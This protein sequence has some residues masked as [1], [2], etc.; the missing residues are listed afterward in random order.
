VL[1]GQD[2]TG[3]L[4]I[5]T[6]NDWN[7]QFGKG[8]PINLT[9]NTG[10]SSGEWELGGLSLRRV[11]WT[12]GAADALI[13]FSQPNPERLES[14]T[15]N[16]GAAS[17]T[18]RGLANA[19]IQTANITAGAGAATLVFDGQL[20]ADTEII[21]DGGVSS[22]AIYSG[23]NP[24]Q[25]TTEGGLKNVENSGWAE[26]G[27]TYTSPEWTGNSP[28]ITVRARLGVATLQLITGQ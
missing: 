9:V 21:L 13:R 6:R 17:L 24:V 3:V 15:V 18:I 10:A 16:G 7:L 26:S 12:Q 25:V 23:G 1:I 20:P 11:T 14:F 22:I 28:K 27:D 5:N 2:F 19:N 8:V 4:P